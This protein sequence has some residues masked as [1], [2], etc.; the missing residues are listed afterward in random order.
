MYGVE[1]PFKQPRFKSS[2]A[3]FAQVPQADI[4]RSVFN[5]THQLK[6]TFDA[7]YLVPIYV[8]EV[9]PGDSFKMRATT[10]ARLATPIAPF[11]DNLYADIHF[12]FVPNRLVWDNWERFNGAQDN[13]DDTTDYLVP[14]VSSPAG[15]GWSSSTLF[16][17]FGIPQG[18]GGVAIDAF[19]SRAYN[20]I[21]NQWYRDQNLQDSVVVD[22]D[23]GPD[24]HTDY[25]LLKR[26]RRHDYFTSC[27]PFTQKGP[28]VTIPFSGDA[29]VKGIGKGT[30]NFD[31]TNSGVYETD[32]VAL[33]TYPFASL[34]DHTSSDDQWYVKGTAATSGRPSIYAD[35]SDV[36]A[37][38]INE[39]REAFQLQRMFERDARGGTRYIEILK[40]HFGVTSPDF[41]LQRPEYLGGGTTVI[42]TSPIPQTSSTDGTSPQG[43][44]A[45][46]GTFSHSQVG[47]NKSFV[48]HGV[49]LGLISVR[50]D[51]TY[52]QGINRMFSRQTRFDFYWPALSHLGEQAVLN[53]EIFA[54]G[55][56]NP[57]Q[58]NAPFGYQERYAE[59][60]YKP[61]LVTGKMSSLDPQS[62]D[63]W[64]LAM[65]YASLPV[66]DS[67]FIEENP[68]VDRVIAVSSEPHFLLDAVFDLKCARPMP[69]YSVPGLIDHF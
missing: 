31:Y 49:L 4:P 36:N 35:L 56:S 34:I 40:S 3:H 25:V 24:T 9:V 11:M 16:N 19:W 17:Y 63:Y 30:Q 44:L 39:L 69:V 14:T 8:D 10:F 53:K 51:Q 43:N 20:L 13:P 6:S 32:Q 28:A 1:Q 45:A 41:R 33:Q 50:A 26:G 59:Y 12:W 68:P 57:T 42:N 27:L 61:S 37:T 67:T 58:D 47:F 38:T 60:R 18:V 64:H 21:W 15:T 65:D 52:Q 5:R 54:V 48:E 2:Q 7:G 46:M 22:K 62:L 23:D 29:P 66:L 55:D